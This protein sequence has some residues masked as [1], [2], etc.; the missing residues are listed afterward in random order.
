VLLW[1]LTFMLVIAA[2]SA[3]CGGKAREGADSP[4]PGGASA[5][6]GSANQGGSAPVEEPSVVEVSGD[7]QAS[8]ADAAAECLSSFQ[9]FVAKSGG[10]TIDFKAFIQEPG[11]YT[12]DALRIL[13]LD[14]QQPD[15]SAYNASTGAANA[16]GSIL[17]HVKTVSPRFVGS[18]EATLTN[19]SDPTEEPLELQL[20][21]DIAARAGCD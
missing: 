4:E 19:R 11:D 10:M 5:V 2:A 1:R 9:G 12:G 16:T 8:V 18:M 3:G 14:V 13:W 15:G 7:I 6:G 21:F 20:S 17:L